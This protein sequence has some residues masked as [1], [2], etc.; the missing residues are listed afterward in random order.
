MASTA[1]TVTRTTAIPGSSSVSSSSMAAASSRRMT[2]TS[3]SSSSPPTLISTI[4]DLYV[5]QGIRGFYKGVTMNWIKGPM[6][7]S[8]SFTC[9]DHIQKNIFMS[10]SSTTSTSSHR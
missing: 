9:Y 4:R 6:A 1:S 5:E 7:F 8:I 10:H 3:S 2:A